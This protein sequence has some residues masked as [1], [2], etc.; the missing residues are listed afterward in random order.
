MND[1]HDLARFLSAQAPVYPQVLAELAAGRKQSH[2]I[3]FIFP[4]MKGLGR[5]PQAE[6]YGIASLAE[7][8]AYLAHPVLGVRLR[9]CTGLVLAC[10]GQFL[11][12]I[13]GFPDNLKFR[14]SMTLFAQAA[15]AEPLFAQALA[16]FCQSEPDSATLALLNPPASRQ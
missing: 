4:Q 11:E 12:A 8:E 5:S 6:F 1:P 13:L 7:A 9:Q 2:W 14:S 10:R 15:P 16:A 3:W